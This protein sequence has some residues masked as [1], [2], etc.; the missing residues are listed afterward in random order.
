MR[1][2]ALLLVLAG[3]AADP[4][5]PAEPPVSE[6]DPPA[7]FALVELFT[8]EGCSSCP[9]ADAAL[10]RLVEEDRP[11]V[12]ALAFHVDYWDRLGWRD[13]FG[14]AAYSERQR[15][16]APMLDRRV[17]TPQAVVNGTRGLVG[18][19]ERELH[20]A[21]E[22]ALA[23][24]AELD[25]LL[26]VRRNDEEVIVSVSASRPPEGAVLYVALVQRSAATDV[27]RGENRGRRLTH[28]NVVRAL[29]SVE[30]GSG[31]VRLLVPREAGEVF[32]AAWAQEGMTGRVLGVATEEV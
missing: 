22:T 18:S 5:P 29:T 32:V 13:P 7:G 10:A 27:P 17:Y 28:V 6:P 31:P 4:V 21:I 24:P 8:S 15:A 14:S 23:T 9:P 1:V 25:L 20:E 19:R 26:N 16:Y 11:G 2:L 30:P 3:C 12:L